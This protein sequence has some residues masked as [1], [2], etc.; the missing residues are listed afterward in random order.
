MRSTG[1]KKVSKLNLV[2]PNFIMIELKG[3]VDCSQASHHWNSGS[4]RS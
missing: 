3:V 1:E 4:N 2:Q